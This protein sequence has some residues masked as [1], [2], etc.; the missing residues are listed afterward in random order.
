MTNEALR[1]QLMNRIDT[2]LARPFLVW[3]DDRKL[4]TALRSYAAIMPDSEV[5]KLQQFMPSE[6]EKQ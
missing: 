6:K 3:G 4:L 1:Q 5:T 2:L